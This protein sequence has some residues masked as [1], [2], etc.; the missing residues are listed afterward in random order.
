MVRF[1]FSPWGIVTRLFVVLAFPTAAWA[2]ASLAVCWLL[3]RLL[4]GWQAWWR[5]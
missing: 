2:I 3:V 5:H 4:L 1:R